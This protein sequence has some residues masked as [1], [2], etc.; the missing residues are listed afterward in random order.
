MEQT[1]RRGKSST[2]RWLT[3]VT[4][5]AIVMAA[6]FIAFRHKFE[7]EPT[8]AG[9]L[10]GARLIDAEQ[11]ANAVHDVFGEDIRVE[12][13]FAPPPRRQGLLSLGSAEMVVTPGLL[14]QFDRAARGV[15][16]QV[17]AEQRRGTLIPCTPGV[18]SQPDDACAA[19]FFTQVGRFL[20]RRS[21]SASEL[22]LHV[23][24]AHEATKVYGDFYAGLAP[25]LTGMMVSPKF[26]Y[27]T[28][29]VEPDPDHP[30]LERLD[31]G[32]KATRL[33]LFLWNS[34]PDDAL[35]RA[36]EAGELHEQ[37]GFERQL[38]RLLA[39]PD[40]LERGVR[41][42]FADLLL[43]DK[44]DGL[45]KDA[46]IYPVFTPLVANSAREQILRQLIDHLLVRG[47]DYRELFTT[48]YSFADGNIAPLQRVPVQG[49]G[50]M[51]VTLEGPQHAGLLTAPGFLAAHSHPGRSSP[52]LRGKAIRE[53][54]LCQRVPDPPPNVDFNLFEG[55]LETMK[56]ARERLAAHSTDPVCAGCHKI[57]DP[58]GLALEKFDGAGVF[59]ATEKG[60]PIDASGDLDGTAFSDAA[61]LGQALRVNRALVPCLASRLYGHGVG[62]E[63]AAG[64]R[65]WL[66]WLIKRFANEGYRYPDLLRL[67]ALSRAFYAVKP[68][69]KDIQE[70]SSAH[71]QTH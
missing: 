69:G 54:L 67:I 70:V 31:G 63:T 48:P 24:A 36:A 53:A 25:S 68:E 11:Y 5:V 66:A 55:S 4:C 37:A 16:A 12:A 9:T 39:V 35:L 6:G 58:I 32:S 18:A 28:E 52:T 30:G 2:W 23:R 10:P 49:T 29:T 44:F 64:D 34:L 62:H 14:E 45:A 43:L 19:K 57:T 33:S 21:L 71:A 27:F 56:T 7:S 13:S 17:V 61:G 40:R 65:P 8:V 47:G 59:R 42:F 15:A 38:E 20:F 60:A 1:L 51:P 22:Q 26:L 46:V 50:W 41:A 3:V